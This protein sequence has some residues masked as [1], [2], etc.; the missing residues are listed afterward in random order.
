MKELIELHGADLEHVLQA[1]QRA[2]IEP[3]RG[4]WLENG[5]FKLTLVPKDEHLPPIL[6]DAPHVIVDFNTG[7][8]WIPN[9]RLEEFTCI[10]CGTQAILDL[11]GNT[12]WERAP[13]PPGQPAGD[14]GSLCPDCARRMTPA[15]LRELVHQLTPLAADVLRQLRASEFTHVEPAEQ[16]ALVLLRHGD[17]L[18]DA[19][20]A[21]NNATE[22]L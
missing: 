17:E 5:H 10:K 6:R 15:A 21:L 11:D 7:K 12:D 13:P 9:T 2:R 1:A 3:H 8:A 22:M 16:L 18:A 4:T 19:L 14:Y 20:E